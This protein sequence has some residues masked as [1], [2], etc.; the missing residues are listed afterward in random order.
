MYYTFL[1]VL[2]INNSLT[3]AAMHALVLAGAVPE[4]ESELY[5]Y[6]STLRP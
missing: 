2:D 3:T 6:R 5:L 1:P 4:T